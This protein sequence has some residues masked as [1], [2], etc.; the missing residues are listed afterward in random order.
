[1]RGWRHRLIEYL[2]DM[3]ARGHYHSDVE[4]V[5][6]VVSA[7]VFMTLLYFSFKTMDRFL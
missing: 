3:L 5:K 4:Q 1:M 6:D 2:V 7:A